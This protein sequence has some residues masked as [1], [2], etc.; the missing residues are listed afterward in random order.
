MRIQIQPNRWSCLPTAFAIV[1]DMH[2]EELI[3][4]I[5]H[6]GSSIKYK[7]DRPQIGFNIQEIIQTLCDRFHIT[8]VCELDLNY[9]TT[10]TLNINRKIKELMETRSGVI[11]VEQPGNF[12]HVLAWD[13][14]SKK[15]IDPKGKVVTLFTPYIFWMVERRYENSGQQGRNSCQSQSSSSSNGE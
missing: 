6:D 12:D 13:H 15:V 1:C 2:V 8:E 7:D 4:K 14:N 5:G 10:N 3:R 11:A 9:N